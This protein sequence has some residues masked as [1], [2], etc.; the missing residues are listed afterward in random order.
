M[1]LEIF[2]RPLKIGDIV[3]CSRVNSASFRA[4]VIIGIT[5]KRARVSYLNSWAGDG[6]KD[7]VCLVENGIKFLTEEETKLYKEICTTHNIIPQ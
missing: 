7:Q 2:D 5:V 4:G 1:S 3:V 6:S